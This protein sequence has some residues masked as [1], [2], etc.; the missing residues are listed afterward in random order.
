M[1]NDIQIKAPITTKT[2]CSRRQVSISGFTA[3]LSGFLL[4]QGCASSGSSYTPPE[5]EKLAKNMRA[6]SISALAIARLMRRLRVGS[7]LPITSET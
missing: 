6:R 7:N 5:P 2:L 1:N 3:L 4:L